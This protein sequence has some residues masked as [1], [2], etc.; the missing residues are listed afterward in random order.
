MNFNK[1]FSWNVLGLIVLLAGGL[2]LMK[3]F[4]PYKGGVFMSTTTHQYLFNFMLFGSM[5][6][7]CGVYYK[8]SGVHFLRSSWLLY[9]Q[10][11]WPF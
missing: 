11:H 7:F 6:Y 10:G 8:F 3:F 1:K 5:V 2:L 4:P 9:L